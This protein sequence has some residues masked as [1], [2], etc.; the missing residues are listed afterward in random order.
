MDGW[1]WRFAF[2]CLIKIP[3]SSLPAPWLVPAGWSAG[4][5]IPRFWMVHNVIH[6]HKKS[7]NLNYKKE[8]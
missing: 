2:T 4:P 1:F 5:S 3:S 7:V 6:D 8:K